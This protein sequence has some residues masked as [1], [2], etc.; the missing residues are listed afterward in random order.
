MV[1]DL[2]VTDSSE[3]ASLKELVERYPED[4]TRSGK[5]LTLED[6]L[7]GI[8]SRARGTYS[9]RFFRS[10]AGWWLGVDYSARRLRTRSADR[11]AVD[12]WAAAA[13]LLLKFVRKP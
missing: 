1:E 8:A 7:A 6:L 9:F 11:P 10:S 2:T 3:P 5:P 13:L 12:R 4:L